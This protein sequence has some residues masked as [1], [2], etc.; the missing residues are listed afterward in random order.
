MELNFGAIVM[1]LGGG[2]ALFLYGMRMMAE[3]LKIVAGEGMKSLMRRFTRNRVMAA[4]TGIGVTAVFQSSS[5]TTV[6]VV[7]FISAGLMSLEQSVGVIIGANLGTTITAQIVAFKVTE[8]SLL[9][10]GVGFFVEL[11]ADSNKL[12]RYGSALMGLGLLFFGM[13]LM[14]QATDPLRSYEPFLQAIRQLD[15]VLIG[16]TIGALFTAVVQSS[17]AT[18]GIVIVFASEGLLP[19]EAGIAVVLGANIGTCVTPL[20]AAIDKPTEAKQAAWIHVIVNLL[21]ALAWIAF[22]PQFAELVRGLTPGTEAASM[23]SVGARQIANAHTIFNLVNLAVFIWFVGP[24]ARLA[25]RLVPTRAVPAAAGV[26]PL[27]LDKLYLDQPALAL[28]R[29]ELEIGRLGDLVIELARDALPVAS[30]GTPDEVER[31]CERDDG[32]DQ[33]HGHIITYLGEL[34]QQNLVDPQP[35]RLYRYIAA[36]NALESIGDVVETGYAYDAGDRLSKGLKVSSETYRHL[37]ALQDAAIAAGRLALQAFA[38]EAADKAAEVESSK[39]DFNRLAD[40]ARAHLARRLIA[41]EPARLDTYRLETDMIENIKRM[42]TL[43][44]RLAKA[45][46]E[47]A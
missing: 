4:L 13:E 3:A 8:F 34:S 35:E 30:R 42:H 32:I 43:F 38:E 33:L 6:L 17:S 31:L 36:A 47:P 22:V 19:L 46:A 5:I 9:M 26:V 1:G 15:N 18:T 21:G 45:V 27:Y 16:V 11:V 44:R 7:G 10:I 12:K 41:E 39:R 24:L 37:Q 40:R 28:D 20:L 29:V 23:A 2:L 14:S 25:A